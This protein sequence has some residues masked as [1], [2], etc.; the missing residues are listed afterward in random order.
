MK[1]LIIE[2]HI[3]KFKKWLEELDSYPEIFKYECLMNY[4]Q[5]WDIEAHD[6]YSMFDTCYKSKISNSLWGGSIN[7]SKSIMLLLIEQNKE[8]VRSMFKDLLNESKD[9]SLR[10]NRFSFHCE[11]MMDQLPNSKNKPVSHKHSPK[12][13]TLYLCFNDPSLYTIIDY[14]NFQSMM[15]LFENANIPMEF[16]IERIIKLCRGLFK[17]L[18]NDEKLI[19]LHRSQIPEEY[20]CEHN[21]LLVHDFI[22]MH[23]FY[24]TY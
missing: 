12:I 10:V 14:R 6:F 4:R 17:I 16:E 23:K 15:Q 5:N 9:L 18:S 24:K 21:M 13:L 2:N 22:M 3:E 1:V 11:E 7:S 8:F 19:E 20:Q